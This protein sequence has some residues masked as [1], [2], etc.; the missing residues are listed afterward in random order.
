M[1]DES[2]TEITFYVRTIRPPELMGNAL[3]RQFS[4]M[5]SNL[6]VYD[7]KTMQTQLDQSLFTERM[8]AMLSAFFGLLATRWPLLDCMA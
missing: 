7:M 3:R 1:Q 6:P 2:A 8:V 5:D 4:E